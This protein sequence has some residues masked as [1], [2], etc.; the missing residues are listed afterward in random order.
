MVAAG[1]SSSLYTKAAFSDIPDGRCYWEANVKAF[2]LKFE[3][4][5]YGCFSLQVSMYCALWKKKKKLCAD[6]SRRCFPHSFF[7]K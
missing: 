6:D 4:S 5:V 2:K 1:K 3:L 7:F